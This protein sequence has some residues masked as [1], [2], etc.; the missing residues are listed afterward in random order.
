M[1]LGR[2]SVKLDLNTKYSGFLYQIKYLKIYCIQTKKPITYT[3]AAPCLYQIFLTQFHTFQIPFQ[4][5]QMN[6]R[7]FQL[8]FKH[9]HVNFRQFQMNFRHNFNSKINIKTFNWVSKNGFSFPNMMHWD[10]QIMLAVSVKPYWCYSVCKNQW[11]HWPL[12]VLH[13]FHRCATFYKTK[14]F[15]RATNCTTSTINSD[16]P[17]PVC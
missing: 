4:I 3:T 17:K 12:Q 2:I 11:N 5:G 14:E 16:T 13:T 1:P 7:R 9:S 6:F 15:E 10:K 8:H